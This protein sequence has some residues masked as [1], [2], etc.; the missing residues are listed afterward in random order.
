[1][2][3]GIYYMDNGYKI[4]AWITGVIV[5][6]LV[7][8]IALFEWGF[9]VG[10]AIGWFPAAI[11]GVVGGLLWPILALLVVYILIYVMK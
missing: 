1:M 4:G 3:N 8:I 2:Y 10:L 9:L 6:F 5:F 7:W 11:A